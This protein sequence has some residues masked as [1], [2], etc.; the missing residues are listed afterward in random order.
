MKVSELTDT[1]ILIDEIYDEISQRLDDIVDDE[2]SHIIDDYNISHI[3]MLQILDIWSQDFSFRETYIV[4]QADKLKKEKEKQNAS[5]E[6]NKKYF[7]N[8]K[9]S[10]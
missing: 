9:A 6:E 2:V 3:V 8:E 10:I 1:D 7:V 5:K 4:K